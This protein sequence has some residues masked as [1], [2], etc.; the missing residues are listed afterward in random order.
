MMR[1]NGY[2]LL[3]ALGAGSWAAQ[4]PRTAPPAAKTRR[5]CAA[6]PQSRIADYR[7]SPEQ[8]LAEAGRALDA[9]ESL[10]ARAGR[11]GCDVLA[12]PEDTLGLLHWELGNPEAAPG[13][14]RQAVDR[15]L[16]RLGRAAAAHRMYLVCSSDAADPDNSIRNTAFLL[17]RDGKEIGRYHKVNLPIHE[18][19]R[20]AGATFPV[21][22]TPDLGG[23]GM[24]IC[25]DMVMPEA[26]RALALAGADIIFVPTLGGAAFGDAELSRAAFRTRAVDNF[27]YLAVAKRGGGALIVSPQ[28]KVLA[29]G[30]EPDGIAV[31]DIDPFGGRQAGDA[32]NSQQDMRARLFRERNPAAYGLLTDPNPPVLKKVPQT[33][34][35]QEA[36]RIA[37]QTLTAGNERFSQ[38]EA[39]RKQGQTADAIR[40][41]EKLIEEFPHTWID[42][43]SRERLAALR[44]GK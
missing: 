38:A 14:L 3:A 1:W 11:N 44:G 2:L 32:L 42:R 26:A 28:G 36:I 33:I 20:K 41:F 40:A 16:A 7:L 5:V 15:M 34:T 21:F 31:A 8:A 22:E 35:A 19:S 43:R 37:S 6:Q 18:S 9:L 17:G 39:L 10:A 30:G 24:L 25:Y 23:I 13:V 4:P 27:V 29:E 12:L